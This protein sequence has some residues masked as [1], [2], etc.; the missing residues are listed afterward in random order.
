MLAEDT[1]PLFFLMLIVISVGSV[2]KEGPLARHWAGGIATVCFL[3]CG[4]MWVRGSG[5]EMLLGGI[6]SLIMMGFAFGLT[7][8]TF[9]LAEAMYVHLWKLPRL[10]AELERQRRESEKHVEEIVKTEEK[11]VPPPP[12]LPPP[13]TKEERMKDA[14]ERHDTTNSRLDAAGLDP[15]ELNAAKLKERQRYLKELDTIL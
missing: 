5:W 8:M 11:P 3:F 15:T 1:V 13:P 14:K 12:P 4:A 10:A 6:Q 9:S 7:L 2:T